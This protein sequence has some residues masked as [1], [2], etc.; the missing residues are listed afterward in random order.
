MFDLE[1]GVTQTRV[2][3]DAEL[4]RLVSNTGLLRLGSEVSWLLGTRGPHF[5]LKHDFALKWGSH[6][7]T[8]PWWLLNSLQL[9]HIVIC[10]N[11]FWLSKF[12]V[13]K[14]Y[15]VFLFSFFKRLTIKVLKLT[16]RGF[17]SLSFKN[18]SSTQRWSQ[19]QEIKM[20]CKLKHSKRKY[21]SFILCKI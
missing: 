2:R 3:W 7:M 20:R 10:T 11:N 15:Y 5:S 18:T 21:F 1:C 14:D 9:S 12:Q 4:L 16:S 17:K 13:Y 6:L 19:A 8:C